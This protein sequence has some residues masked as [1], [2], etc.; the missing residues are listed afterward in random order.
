MEAIEEYVLGIDPGLTLTG[1]VLYKHKK[2]RT[3]LDWATH[4][5][6]KLGYTDLQR[7]ASLAEAILSTAQVWCHKYDIQALDACLELPIVRGNVRAF[8]K[9]M[10][11]IQEIEVGLMFVL[12]GK[13]RPLANFHLVEVMPTESKRLATGSGKADKDD[14]IVASPLGDW[15]M[16]L[17]RDTQEAL[18]DAWGHGQAAYGGGGKRIDLGRIQAARV[19]SNGSEY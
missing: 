14:M 12:I 5:S 16:G 13:D 15:D 1:M 9:Q 11:L 17:D 8:G 19:V 18:A 4:A 10:R 2:D 7:V 3:L 6:P